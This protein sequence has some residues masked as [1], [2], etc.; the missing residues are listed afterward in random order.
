MVR[1]IGAD[2]VIDYTKEDFTRS[3]QH[4]DILYDCIGNHSLSEYGRVLNPH[5][6][7][8]MAGGKTD[9]WMMGSLVS[10]ITAP[11]LSRLLGKKFL[12]LIARRSKEDLNILRELMEAGKIRPVIDRCHALNEVPEAIRYLEEGHARGKVVVTMGQNNKT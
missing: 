5:G 8:V 11:V 2:R 12:T 9:R 10:S 1:S 7:C 4:Y 6:I 3:G